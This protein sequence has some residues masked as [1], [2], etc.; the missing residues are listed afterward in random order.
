MTPEDKQPMAHGLTRR[1]MA[2][3]VLRLALCPGTAATTAA[4]GG[5]TVLDDPSAFRDLIGSDSEYAWFV[6]SAPFFESSDS[7]L[8]EVRTG[9]MLNASLSQ[10]KSALQRFRSPRR[11][12]CR[13]HTPL[14]Q[15]LSPLHICP[16]L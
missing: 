10:S 2:M 8:T 3:L 6:R 15:T 14:F 12:L 4:P 7:D 16:L 9:R 1:T 5:L 13:V 11:L